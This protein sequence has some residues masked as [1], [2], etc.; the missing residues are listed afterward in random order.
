MEFSNV[1]TI[2]KNGVLCVAAL[3]VLGACSAFAQ[4]PML[5]PQ[6]RELKTEATPFRV[7]AGLEIALLSPASPEDAFAAATLQRE[8]WRDTGLIFPIVTAVGVPSGKPV[9]LLGRLDQPDMAS[10]LKNQ[11]LSPEGIA[12][13]GYA[14]SIT[15]QRVLVAGKDAVG[16]F[17]GVQTLRQLVVP[18]GGGEGEIL[19]AQIRDWPALKYRGTQVDLA[20]GPVPKLAYLK[21]IV[22]TIAAFKMNQLYLYMEDSFRV[23]GQPLIGVLSDTLTQQDWRVLVAYA[24]HYHVNV[25]PATEDCGHLHQI[26]RF[27]Q[28]SGMAE[29]PHGFVLAPGDPRGIDF[30]KSIYAQLLPIFPSKFYNIGCDETFELGLGRSKEMVKQE[31]YGKV[32]VDYLTKIYHLVRS[33]NK[34]V[35]FWGDIAV[36]HP[37]MVPSLPKGLIVASWVY[38]AQKSYQR[39]L[40]P[41]EGTGMRIFICPWTGNTSLIAPDYEEAAYNIRQ[42]IA[43]GKKAGAIGTDV[44]VWND[45]GESLYGPNWWSIV[46]GA[47]C[48][49]EPGNPSVEDF[50]RK[51]DWAFFRDPSPSLVNAIMELGHLNEVIRAG[52]P[53]KTYDMKRGGAD[54]AKFWHDPFSPLWQPEVVKALPIASLIRMTAEGAYATMV[55]DRRLARRNADVLKDMEFA[56]LKMDALGMRYQYVQEISDRYDDA[57]AHQNDRTWRQTGNDLSDIDSTNGRLQDLRDYT[58][59]LREIYMQR[60]LSENLPTWLPNMLQLYDR[61][62]RMWQRLIAKYSDLR[63]AHYRGQPLPPPESLGLLPAAQA[64]GSTPANP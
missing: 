2:S 26:L 4:Q 33:Y 18:T 38:G 61:N 20:R 63:A 53:V 52:R 25:V 58:T 48:A 28:Y 56:A 23:K 47:A 41:F 11:G 6:P 1:R 54:D 19:G 8:L 64:S 51:F 42:F 21:R 5:I 16:L 60:W 30:L 45:D 36:E 59:R 10:L 40:K 55:N 29:R 17:Y 46:Y 43:D 50:D 27:E 7:G 62:S 22:R 15:P 31:G 12:A 39:W 24:A 32:Y 14:L 9:I 44:T 57:Y 49:W 37:E 35:M 13:Q 34:Q 3:M